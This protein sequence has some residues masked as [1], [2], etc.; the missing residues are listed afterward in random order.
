MRL[1][2]DMD[3]TIVDT[4]GHALRLGMLD[5][6]PCRWNFDECCS[7]LRPSSD[8]RAARYSQDDVFT[9]DGIFLDADPIPGALDA[10]ERLMS[11][12]DVWFCT[13]PW[14]TNS[15]SLAEKHAWLK[16]HG[17]GW[18]KRLI[19]TYDKTF[20]AAAYLVDD[21]PDLCRPGQAEWQHILYPQPWNDSRWPSWADGLAERI[22]GLY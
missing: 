8:P 11:A 5:H 7:A 15:L 9:T 19:T 16:T 20:I 17:D 21:K 12:H 4:V 2:L 6:Y 1:L 14:P 10:I 22:M 13:T 3:G 18:H